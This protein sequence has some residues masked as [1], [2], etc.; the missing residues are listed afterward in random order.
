MDLGHPKGQMLEFAEE[1]VQ[2]EGKLGACLGRLD[3]FRLGMSLPKRNI[4]QSLPA[5]DEE[6]GFPSSGRATAY[7]QFC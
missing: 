2:L 1:T 3:R 5:R 4:P 7:H 6:V